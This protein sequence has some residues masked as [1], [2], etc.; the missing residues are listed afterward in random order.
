MMASKRK[1]LKECQSLKMTVKNREMTLKRLALIGKILKSW[2]RWY[3]RRSWFPLD[4]LGSVVPA[5]WTAFDLWRTVRDSQ[6]HHKGPFPTLIK[7]PTND[8]GRMTRNHLVP[9]RTSPSPIKGKEWHIKRTFKFYK[10][11]LLISD[12]LLFHT[13]FLFLIRRNPSSLVQ[14]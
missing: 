4:R 14:L 11:E 13:S 5:W 3:A 8:Y 2:L 12:F 7:M 9:K 1:R 6:C 10:L